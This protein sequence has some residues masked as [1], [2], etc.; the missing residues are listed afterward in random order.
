MRKVLWLTIVALVGCVADTGEPVGSLESAQLSGPDDRVELYETSDAVL[1]EIGR[2]SVAALMDARFVDRDG[3]RTISLGELIMSEFDVA[4]CDDVPFLDQPAIAG[5]T[6]TLIDDDLI[7]TA[8]HCVPTQEFCDDLAIVFDY[9]YAA[10]GRLEEIGPEDVYTCTSIEVISY[11]RD[12][13][14]IRLDRE[15][16]APHQPATVRKGEDLIRAGERLSVLSHGLG[17]PLKVDDASE[18]GPIRPEGIDTFY[19]S[20]D[21]FGGSSGAPILDRRGEV[22]GVVSRGPAPDFDDGRCVGLEALD[23]EDG[24]QNVASYV[25]RTM[26]R[27]C[28]GGPGSARLCRDKKAWCPSCKSGGCSAG[29]PLNGAGLALFAFALVL[30]ARRRRR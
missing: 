20:S 30:A 23:V 6:G 27:L 25:H 7:L 22:I 4:A 26:H 15:V 16:E 11:L 24:P 28:N 9:H 8:S 12:Q 10:E 13:A 1:Q 18:M 17:L 3:L 5:C 14:I 19:Y 21:V 29:G 2:R